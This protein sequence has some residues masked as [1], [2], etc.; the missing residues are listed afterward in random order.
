MKQ[1]TDIPTGV[2]AIPVDVQKAATALLHQQMWC[3]GYD[4]R[5]TEG[6]V[7][8]RYT[9]TRQRPPDPALGSSRY[10]LYGEQG[11]HITLWGFGVWYAR[12]EVGGIFLQRYGFSPRLTST[13]ESPASIW[14]P[15]DLPPLRVPTLCK[16]GH[17]TL[18]LLSSLL[19]WM[20]GYEQWIQEN[21]GGAYR[22]CSLKEWPHQVIPPENMATMWQRLARDCH[23][24]QRSTME[25]NTVAP[26]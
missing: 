24:W 8:L 25:A 1:E 26:Q 15:H 23:T 16:E 19:S 22:K 9:F 20:S 5:H 11:Q 18:V 4:I 10:T 12:A 13:I 2:I 14:T 21:L 7:L 6:N 17:T 3:W